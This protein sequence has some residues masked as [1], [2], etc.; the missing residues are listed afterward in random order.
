[1]MSLI[2]LPLPLLLF[3]VFYNLWLSSSS[4][5]LSSP[6]GGNAN[7]VYFQQLAFAVLYALVVLDF[8]NAAVGRLKA[9]RITREGS[10]GKCRGVGGSSSGLGLVKVQAGVYS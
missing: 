5:P 6:G 10:S 9:L 4:L 2:S 8:L 3:T 7:Y 1:M